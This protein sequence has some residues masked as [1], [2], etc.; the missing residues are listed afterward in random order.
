VFLIG[1]STSFTAE[2]DGRLFLRMYDSDPSD[3][4]GKVSVYLE[5]TFKK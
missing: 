3:N 2:R 4:L 1:S 5:G